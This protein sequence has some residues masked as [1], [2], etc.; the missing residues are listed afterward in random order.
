MN[1]KVVSS[2]SGI[3]YTNQNTFYLIEDDWDDWFTYST[4]FNL[5]YIDQNLNIHDIGSL[6]IGQ[7]GMLSDQRS[8]DIPSFFEHL[9]SNFFSLGQSTSYY[10][11]L[12]ELDDP[13]L[14]DEV[15]SALNDIAINED[16]L[17]K[18][19]KEN[20]TRISLLRDIP[21]KTVRVQFRRIANGGVTLTPYHFSYTS[22]IEPNSEINPLNISFKV[23]PDS[24]PP[25]NIH[26]LIGRNGV[27]KTHL[28]KNIINCIINK[29]NDVYGSLN[30]LSS[31]YDE[32]SFTNVV[33][34]S[35]S[36]FD[37]DIPIKKN[38]SDIPFRYI[39]L[40]QSASDNP[41]KSIS[42]SPNDLD[43]EFAESLKSCLLG[44]KSK[45]RLFED[46]I[47]I[48]DSDPIFESSGIR[49][50]LGYANDIRKLSP[51]DRRF[52]IDDEKAKFTEKAIKFFGKLSSGHK[53]IILTITRLIESVEEKTL[54]FLDE[55]ESH[56][57][58]PL[59]SAFIRSLSELMKYKNAVSIIATH[60][61]VVL[62]EV[63]ESCVWKLKRFGESSLAERL[64]FESFG[65]NVSLLTSEIFGLEVTNSGYHTILYDTVIKNKDKDYYSILQMFNNHLGMEAKSILRGIIANES[66]DI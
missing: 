47:N 35:F 57:H 58:P 2:H 45:F 64:R 49:A 37:K 62:Q 60:S 48:L 26:V 56:L 15:L 54:I 17:I 19:S 20:V 3:D 39:G 34:V 13:Y 9:D 59:L 44:S 18:A 27:G 38:N 46:S 66:E 1:F 61:P 6:K 11:N 32:I 40:G 16:L 28:I 12:N 5:L 10:E 50:F 51:E 42:K 36:A 23:E 41:S 52:S 8:P 53:I 14:R 4:L 29:N 7:F 22:Y 63:P 43:E 30:D 33:F 31:F 65:E 55:P 24:L 21:I 25:T